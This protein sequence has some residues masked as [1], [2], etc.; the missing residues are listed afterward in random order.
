MLEQTI[1][2]RVQAFFSHET[3]GVF[4]NLNS[5]LRA[6]CLIGEWITAALNEVERFEE[7]IPW[8]EIAALPE[9]DFIGLSGYEE[10]ERQRE[11]RGSDRSSFTMD[12]DRTEFLRA[13]VIPSISS[14]YPGLEKYVRTSFAIR[15]IMRWYVTETE[16][17]RK[18]FTRPE[19]QE[20]KE[21]IGEETGIEE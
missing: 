4:I 7:G 1:R 5:S 11:Q 17:G 6:P 8:T 18:Y 9:S 14:H 16:E 2:E 20:E 21:D 15:L 13:V 3:E 12:E 19:Q 10:V